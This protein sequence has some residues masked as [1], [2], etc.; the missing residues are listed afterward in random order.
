MV[1]TEGLRY[2]HG[3]EPVDAPPQLE[4][5]RPVALKASLCMNPRPP[6]SPPSCCVKLIITTS[7][8]I[9]RPSVTYSHKVVPFVLVL[10][11]RLSCLTRSVCQLALSMPM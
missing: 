1:G 5:T 7:V 10:V 8:V 11:K 4:R 3:R 6:G 9:C 2:R